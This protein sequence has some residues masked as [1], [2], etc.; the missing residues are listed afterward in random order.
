M[1]VSP[2]WLLASQRFVAL[3]H[4]G[5][6]V[7]VSQAAPYVFWETLVSG[8]VGVPWRRVQFILMAASRQCIVDS[9]VPIF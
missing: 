8:G 1:Q 4:R 5:R 7:A 3:A 9:F 2:P 6:L